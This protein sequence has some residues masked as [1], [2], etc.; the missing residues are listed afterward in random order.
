[1]QMKFREIF[2]NNH[3]CV[4]N[5]IGAHVP[6]TKWSPVWKQWTEMWN[7]RWRLR[8]GTLSIFLTLLLLYHRKRVKGKLKHRPKF[9]QFA[10]EAPRVELDL[11]DPPAAFMFSLFSVGKRGRGW[12]MWVFPWKLISYFS[13]RFCLQKK[14]LLLQ[15]ETLIKTIVLFSSRPVTIHIVNNDE[16]I[17]RE[18]GSDFLRNHVATNDTR[19][20]EELALS[21]A[22]VSNKWKPFRWCQHLKNKSLILGWFRSRWDTRKVSRRWFTGSSSAQQPDSSSRT[23][24]PT[25]MPASSSTT[26]SLS[27]TTLPPSGTDLR[28]SRLKPPW[29]WLLWKPIMAC[30]WWEFWELLTIYFL[31]WL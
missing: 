28:S 25:L 1:M 9:H 10:K 5:G 14:V 2:G 21:F 11:M 18:I 4:I 24:S 16:E 17:F 27:W 15:I 7:M 22:P 13:D 23:S 31:H 8:F 6:L 29:L 3:V 30:G 26:T 12:I 20:F 19:T